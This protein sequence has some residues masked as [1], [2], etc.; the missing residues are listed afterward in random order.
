[1]SVG[2]ASENERTEYLIFLFIRND[3][4]I[5]AGKVRSGELKHQHQMKMYLSK[6]VQLYFLLDF[7]DFLESTDREIFYFHYF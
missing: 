1:M 2:E 7:E 4:K 3:K 6:T 5:S